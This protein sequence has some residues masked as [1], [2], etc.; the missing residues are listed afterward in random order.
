MSGLPPLDTGLADRVH[1]R[2]ARCAALIALLDDEV[3]VDEYE[4]RLVQLDRLYP[5]RR[6]K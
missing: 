4:K 5:D 3:T 6:P 2:L 1:Y